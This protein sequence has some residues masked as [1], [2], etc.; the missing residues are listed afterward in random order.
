MRQD[1]SA[2]GVA[3]CIALATLPN[4]TYPADVFPTSRFY[5]E[6]LAEPE[7]VLDGPARVR[8]LDRPGIGTAPHPERLARRTL[9]HA[10][11]DPGQPP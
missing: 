9:Q 8:A 10:V 11:V 4:F 2:V 1:E 7:I 5:R 6:D 3:H